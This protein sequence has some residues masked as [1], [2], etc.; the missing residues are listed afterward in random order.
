[1]H[2][3][4]AIPLGST[5]GARYR[6]ERRI[7]GGSFG[8]V[9]EATDLVHGGSVALKVIAPLALDETGG[10]ERFHRE[11]ELAS[12]LQHPCSV[13]VFGSGVDAHGWLFIAF[14]LLRG[15]SLEA[16]LTAD[17]RFSEER[18]AR[19]AIDVLSALEEAHGR[20][21]IHRDIKPANIFLATSKGG[22]AVKVVDFGLA[23]S[24][25]PGT[26]VGLPRA[27]V[28]LGTPLY[29]APEQIAG[30]PVGPAT[31]LASRSASSSQSSFTDVRSTKRRIR[32]N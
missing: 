14:E 27:D 4:A 30:D 2:D 26:R 22:E 12:R 23:K 18:A 8:A 25:N 29:I 20:G 15:R 13:R 6:L 10:V 19:I 32:S 17:G 11:A 16:A 9:F 24:T 21:I 3:P 31:D 7:G 28:V 1:M 5:L